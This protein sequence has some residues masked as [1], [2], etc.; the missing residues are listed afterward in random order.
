MFVKENRSAW[1]RK[2]VVKLPKGPNGNRSE[3][4]TFHVKSVSWD[5]WLIEPA[6]FG[7]GAYGFSFHS[8][9]LHLIRSNLTF[10][11]SYSH[12]ASLFLIDMVNSTLL[13]SFSCCYVS[14]D[15]HNFPSTAHFLLPCSI[16]HLSH[17]M[18]CIFMSENIFSKLCLLISFL[19]R[20]RGRRWES[21]QDLSRKTVQR[22]MGSL[23]S[24]PREVEVRRWSAPAE[25]RQ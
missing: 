6:D 15:R 22:G 17:H 18:E 23:M 7:N 8:Y 16:I 9:S 25:S 20:V 1:G 12:T 13:F 14:L 21:D 11:F 3:W 5:S 4:S 24:N 19:Q 2:H 10:S